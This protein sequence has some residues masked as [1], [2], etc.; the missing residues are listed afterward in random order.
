MDREQPAALPPNGDA[1][2]TPGPSMPPAGRSGPL[3]E[4]SRRRFLGAAGLGAGTLAVIGAGG[5]TWRAVSQ[6]VFATGT[7]AAYAAWDEWN[8]PGHAPLNLVR[9]AVLAASAHNTQ[10]WLFAVTPAR[11]D[12]FAVPSRNIGTID[13]LRREMQISLGCALEN[14]VLA[15][16]PHG[17]APTVTLMPD[18]ADTTHVARVDLAPAPASISPLFRAIP[19]R[20]TNRAVYETSRPLAPGTLSALEGLI[21]N[22]NVD[23]AWLTSAAGKRAFGNLTV[24]A[25]QAIIADPQQSADDFRWYRSTW[26]AI[27]SDKDGITSDASGLS[28]LVAAL[29]KLLPASHRQYDDSWL[30]ST[31]DTQ[32]PTAA[33]F[34]TLVVR[35]P[36]DPVQRLLTGRTWQRMHLWATTKGLAMQPFNQ[37]EERMDRERTADLT[38]TFTGAM[39]GILPAGWH[40]VFSFRIGYPTT[41]ASPSPRRPAE[42]VVQH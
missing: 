30:T 27:Q 29:A 34:G 31:R 18:P 14:L 17:M 37:V 15:G 8:P 2:A 26:N 35:D 42:A 28:P 19:H 7:G 4:T 24:R 36:L 21:G 39:A 22:P 11:I 12:L 40:P 41:Q 32:I 16:P 25:T 13:P 3:P 9:A 6:G 33:A 38:P 10:P 20:H 5:L 23:V 1:G